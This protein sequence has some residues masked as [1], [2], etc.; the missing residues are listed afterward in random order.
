M[1]KVL[2]GCL[3]VLA[4]A[5][6]LLAVGGYYFVYR[7]AKS[8]MASFQQ[9]AEVEELESR[10]TN[11]TV[12]V[13]PDN[14]EL[15]GDQVERFMEVAGRIQEQ[16]GTRA[17][18]L[19]EKYDSIQ[20]GVGGDDARRSLV[21]AM[22]SL[23][24]LV[25]FFVEGKRAQVDALNALGFSLDEYEW[26][27]EQVFA[28]AGVVLTEIDLSALRNVGEGGMPD[29]EPRRST[30]DEEAVPERNRALVKPYMEKIREYLPLGFFGL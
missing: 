13:V 12:F 29:L 4:L 25:D 30:P 24:D 5:V 27:R 20:E 28:A 14:G 19:K 17:R 3:V 1:K 11:K 7:P 9:L 21:A 16:L 6:V 26:V 23:R 8:Y 22:A 18:Q 10:V 2:V 15:T